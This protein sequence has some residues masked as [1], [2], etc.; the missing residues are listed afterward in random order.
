MA[1]YT[2]QDTY[3]QF[4]HSGGTTVITTLRSLEDGLE[5]EYADATSQ[6][7]RLRV[8]TPLDL[9]TCEPVLTYVETNDTVGGVAGTAIKAAL[10]YQNTGTLV[11]GP[12]GTVTGLP[13]YG[14]ACRIAMNTPTMEYES[15]IE[16]QV[17]FKNTGSDWV[18][19]PA[20]ATW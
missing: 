10:I 15:E 19:D 7:D 13:K 11:W 1:R 12:M 9:A 5:E 17:T 6:G 18:H 14:I 4:I 16:R 2:G 20:S 8:N 3:V